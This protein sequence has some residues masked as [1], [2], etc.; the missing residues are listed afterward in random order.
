[1][2]VEYLGFDTTRHPFDD[3]RVRRAFAL[4]LDRTRLVE[5]ADG[6]PA[7]PATSVV[8]PALQPPN[9]STQSAAQP[10]DANRLLDDAGFKDRSKLGSIT[11]TVPT[12]FDASPIVA[13]WRK[14]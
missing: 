7:A 12:F 11:V 1:L 6:A 2:S 9:L 4:V 10:G 13:T 3:A 5:L 8:P 14:Q